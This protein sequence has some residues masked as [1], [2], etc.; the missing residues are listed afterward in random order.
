MR[1]P[2]L[3]PQLLQNNR[4]KKRRQKELPMKRQ[5]LLLKLKELLRRKLLK[6]LK[7]REY[8]RLR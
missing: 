5:L 4:G 3:K 6:K 8:V 7:K 2:E 1:R